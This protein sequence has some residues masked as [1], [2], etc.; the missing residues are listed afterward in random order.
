MTLQPH[1][2]EALP[3]ETRD[4]TLARFVRDHARLL[5]RVAFTILRNPEDSEDAVQDALLKLHRLKELPPLDHERAYL[6]RI[7]FRTAL[8]RKAARRPNHHSDG[9]TQA[10]LPDP[11]PTPETATAR[12]DEQAL[13]NQLI[14]QLPDDLRET[15]LLSAIQGLN[16]RE[17]G[18]ILGIAEG[19]VRT[20]L[21]R[22]RNSLRD[23][24]ESLNINRRGRSEV[25]ATAERSS[26]S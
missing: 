4:Q 2:L 21:L 9:P 11:R 22:A 8:D 5:Y 25:A 23:Q 26:F 14:D 13:L 7:V 20:R 17:A 15:L 19:T 3:N 18:E 24:F 1:P 12:D 16:S 10:T 6:C